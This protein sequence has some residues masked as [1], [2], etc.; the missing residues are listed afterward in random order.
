MSDN[1]NDARSRLAHALAERM[2][3]FEYR[4]R[5]AVYSETMIELTRHIEDWLLDRAKRGNP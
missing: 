5:G 1:R 2:L 3:T 4:G